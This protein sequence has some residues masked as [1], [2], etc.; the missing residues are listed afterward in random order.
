MPDFP[1]HLYLLTPD[2]VIREGRKGGGR[3]GRGEEGVI[4]LSS[5]I[6]KGEG[7]KE[8]GE[9]GGENDDS[10]HISFLYG[11]GGR[12][13]RSGG[14]K[15]EKGK[16]GSSSLSF[17]FLFREDKGEGIERGKRERVRK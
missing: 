7:E 3:K 14:K 1:I 5:P 8:G 9:R 16:N 6:P 13:K 2:R 11:K 17:L 10:L 15:E 4:I 12:R